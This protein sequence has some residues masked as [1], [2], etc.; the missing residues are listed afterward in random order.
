[1][2]AYL[3]QKIAETTKMVNEATHDQQ[4][5]ALNVLYDAAYHSKNKQVQVVA[6][7]MLGWLQLKFESEGQTWSRAIDVWL[8]ARFPSPSNVIVSYVVSWAT[9]PVPDNISDIYIQPQID[10]AEPMG[11]QL[12]SD[13]RSDFVYSIYGTTESSLKIEGMVRNDIATVEVIRDG[14]GKID[15]INKFTPWDKSFSYTIGVKNGNMKLGGNAYLIRGYAKDVVY[16]ALVTIV[17]LE[18]WSK[19]LLGGEIIEKMEWSAG[20]PR[21][22]KFSAC[23]EDKQE[24]EEESIQQCMS[25]VIKEATM[26][27]SKACSLADGHYFNY[28][29]AQRPNKVALIS[30]FYKKG[31]KLYYPL[32]LGTSSPTCDDS[33]YEI[34]VYSLDC[35]SNERVKLIANDLSEEKFAKCDMSIV[36]ANDQHILLRKMPYEWYGETY[37]G[38]EILNLSS[39]Q[40]EKLRLFDGIA[41][42]GTGSETMTR[43]GFANNQLVIQMVEKIVNAYGLVDVVSPGFTYE[44]INVT[45]DMKATVRITIFALPNVTLYYDVP[46][47]LAKKAFIATN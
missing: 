40:S 21:I 44:I 33:W 29:D 1:M 23:Y 43:S 19:P 3:Q 14:D 17:Y 26:N 24:G 46:V 12:I 25:S 34:Y 18:P 38:Y 4:Q 13:G 6:W 30:Q 11:G 5:R 9:K 28:L 15:T 42:L 2:P 22:S 8:L 41:L 10:W 31:D 32:Q 45:D 37:E 20:D 36:Y 47:D 16:S 35:G 7:S 27:Q 39:R